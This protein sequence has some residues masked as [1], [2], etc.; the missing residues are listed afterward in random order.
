MLAVSH[1]IHDA[2]D[3]KARPVVDVVDAAWWV[4]GDELCSK[5]TG[6]T[7]MW[8]S[9]ATVRNRPIGAIQ[10]NYQTTIGKSKAAF[11]F[12][13]S[14]LAFL[15]LE[16]RDQWDGR[17]HLERHRSVPKWRCLPTT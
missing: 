9:S 3:E 6:T 11:D 5:M 12:A 15:T 2:F 8:Q 13:G 4:T 16:S 10:Q 14:R 1:D 17:S 7:V